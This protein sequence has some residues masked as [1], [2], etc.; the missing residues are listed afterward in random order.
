MMTTRMTATLLSAAATAVPAQAQQFL[1]LTGENVGKYPAVA[2]NVMPVPGPGFP[3]TFNDGDRLAGTG[4]DGPA[5]VFQGVGTPLYPPNHVGALS[6]MFKRG[7]IPAGPGMQVPFMGIDFMGGPRL[8]LDGDLNN[9]T[10]S[11]TPVGTATPVELVGLPSHALLDVSVSAGTIKL[12]QFDATG[13]NEGG[14]GVS[15]KIATIVVTTAGTKP[16]G[17]PGTAPNPG[18]DTRVGALSPW[19]GTAGVYEIKN[20]AF[21]LWQDSIDP[22][23]ASA[24]TLGTLQYLAIYRGWLVTRDPATGKFP[25]LAGKGLGGTLWPKV[26]ATQVGNTFNTANGLAGG[27]AVIKDGIGGDNF[28]APNN[29]GLALTSFGGDLGAYLDAVVLPKVPPQASSCLYLEGAGFGMNNSFDPVYGDT[30]GYDSV[31]IA[32]GVCPGDADGDGAI[33]QSDLGL[34]L[35]AYGTVK[36][37][38]GYNAAADQDF[39]GD[40]DQSDLGILLAEFGTKC[41]E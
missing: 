18:Y 20:F 27:T 38:P 36:G 25:T 7:S 8:D 32:A 5:V 28:T 19:P 34:L 16:D 41:M 29:G 2:R 40:V 9:G 10:R 23:S 6:F 13:T 30:I 1:L 12:V 37:A 11:L 35:A 33:G 17:T 39:D 15:A 21:E 22:A 24:S 31:F 26:D 14:P 3:G 4:D